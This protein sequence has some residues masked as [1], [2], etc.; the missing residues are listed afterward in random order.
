MS[1]PINVSYVSPEAIIA[2]AALFPSLSIVF[3][4][5]RFYVRRV[6]RMKLLADD[7]L[8]IPALVCSP[9]PGVRVSSQVEIVADGTTGSYHWDGY[10][11]DHW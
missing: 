6:Q 10:C 9:V 1:S 2:V 3:V 11:L 5:L 8:L 7:W 4:G